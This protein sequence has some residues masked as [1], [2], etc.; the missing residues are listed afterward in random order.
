MP[1]LLSALFSPAQ[2]WKAPR[3][4]GVCS[5]G[6]LL[7]EVGAQACVALPAPLSGYLFCLSV[8]VLTHVTKQIFRTH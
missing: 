8:L 7:A 2:H 5:V 6:G 3:E 4:D 1:H